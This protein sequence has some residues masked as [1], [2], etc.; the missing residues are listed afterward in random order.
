MRLARFHVPEAGPGSRVHFPDHV[1]HHAREVLR[2]PSGTAVRVF[3]GQGNEYEAILDAVTRQGVTARLAGPVAAL[4]ES[5]LRISLAISALKGDLME[6]V[7][8]KT[9][10]L[11]VNELR[12]VIMARTDAVARPALRGSRQQ[13]WEKVAS[14]AA[15]QCGRAVVPRIA[16]TATLESLVAEPF[17]GLRIALLAAGAAPP[18]PSLALPPASILVLVGPAGGFDPHEV[19]QL[20]AAGFESAGL[21]ARTLRAETAAVIAVAALQLLWGDLR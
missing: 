15:E 5:P 13:R 12:P 8:E 4:P 11:G 9:T 6:W 20:E 16:P 7:I 3:D 19:R 14:G 10:E 2:L 17:A 18:L 21:G 1:A